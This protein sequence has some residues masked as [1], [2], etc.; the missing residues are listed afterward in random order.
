MDYD[1]KYSEKEFYW[2]LKPHNLVVDSIQHLPSNANV[3]DLGCGEG[4]NSFFLAKKD[5]AV[6]AVDISKKGI[7]KLKEFSKKEKLKINTYISD[8]KSYLEDCEEFNA[9]F[10]MNILLFIDQKNIF[11][12]IKQIQSKTKPNGL[13]IIASFIAKTSKQKEMV[14]SKGMY[15][16]DE[17]ELREL[18]K[19]WKIIFYEE[20][21]GNWE[22]HGKSRHRHFPVKLIA[23]KL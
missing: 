23:Q 14:L 3:L 17:G 1:S 10:A 12:T 18:Y 4:K 5:F 6:T 19:D 8:V 7:T 13:N 21:L 2:G 15:F 22:T 20:K 9:I 11:N 16:F